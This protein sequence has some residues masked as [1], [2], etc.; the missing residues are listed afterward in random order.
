MACY[1]DRTETTSFTPFL[2]CGFFFF[3]RRSL[4]ADLERM[5]DALAQSS[6]A[7]AGASTGT[8]TGNGLLRCHTCGA[9]GN[10]RVCLGCH[11][12]YY[13]NKVCISPSPTSSSSLFSSFRVGHVDMLFC[14]RLGMSKE[15]LDNA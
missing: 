3:F 11:E 2:L 12:V 1:E 10:V 13:C 5:T 14:F 15:R 6:P 4:F 8:K 9:C 7:T